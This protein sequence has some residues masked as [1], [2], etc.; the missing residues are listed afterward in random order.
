MKVVN[1]KCT[2]PKFSNKRK[3]TP[4]FEDKRTGYYLSDE[5]ERFYGVITTGLYSAE[6]WFTGCSYDVPYAY[7]RYQFTEITVRDV[8]TGELLEHKYSDSGGYFETKDM[9]KCPCLKCHPENR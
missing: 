9:P 4:V 6:D 2:C 8:E 7:T 5:G 3:I 1:Y